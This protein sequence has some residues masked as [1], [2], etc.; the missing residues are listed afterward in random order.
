MGRVSHAFF[1]AP[2]VAALKL[3]EGP[4]Q[5]LQ[6]AGAPQTPENV[7]V[8]Q[9][10][11]QSPSIKYLLNG[12]I[13]PEQVDMSMAQ[14]GNQG[15]PVVSVYHK[16]G[17]VFGLR[18]LGILCD[19]WEGRE[20]S[21]VCSSEADE[22]CHQDWAKAEWDTNFSQH[23]LDYLTQYP[24]DDACAL[25]GAPTSS[26]EFSESKPNIMFYRNPVSKI[27]SAYRYHSRHIKGGAGGLGVSERWLAKN[28][29]CNAC[30]QEDHQLLFEFCDG[31]SY[32]SLLKSVNEST[33]VQLELLHSGKEL[34]R[35][36]QVFKKHMNDPNFLYVTMD[37]LRTDFDG[38]AKCMLKFMGRASESSNQA[39]WSRI[40]KLDISGARSSGHSTHYDFDNDKTQS[41]L[42]SHS[43]L[44]AAF[45]EIKATEARVFERQ[46]KMYGCP[47]PAL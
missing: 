38:T 47:I 3:S 1:L 45:A 17:W 24:D 27:L 40:K 25:L 21:R 18:V 42:E 10:L 12:H 28:A 5:L 31:C 26:V 2:A 44:G 9:A 35:M 39:L 33:A 16:T 34:M 22:K 37:H 46:H 15:L 8:I 41:F 14:N 20:M 29:T 43:L 30:G 36:L 7:D 13:V 23:H 11:K 19:E 4:F 32:N 6:A